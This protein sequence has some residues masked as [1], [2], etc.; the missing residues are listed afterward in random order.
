MTEEVEPALSTGWLLLI[1]VAAVA[2]LLFLIMKVRLHAFLALIVV[3]LVTALATRIPVPDVV[4]PLSKGSAPRSAAW[5]CWWPS[6][7]SWA[8]S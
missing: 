7:R 2:V 5:R 8:A 3:S 4:P 6:A 1:L